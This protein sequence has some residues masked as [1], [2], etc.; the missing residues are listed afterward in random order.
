MGTVMR[1]DT[2]QRSHRL[3]VTQPVHPTTTTTRSP[4]TA[5]GQ[6]RGCA[7]PDEPCYPSLTAL[8]GM[9][10]SAL[11]NRPRMGAD[12]IGPTGRLAMTLRVT[13][14]TS[15]LALARDRGYDGQRMGVDTVQPSRRLAHPTTRLPDYPTTRLPDYPTTRLPATRLPRAASRSADHATEGRSAPVLSAAPSIRV[16]PSRHASVPPTVDLVGR[17]QQPK[18]PTA[19][20]ACRRRDARQ[21]RHGIQD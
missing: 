15:S 7:G 20:Y 14:V 17:H 19:A 21:R 8:T 10:S 4:R 3:A 1:D 6:G 13:R 5:D 16:A 2:S 11:Y 18:T 12:A 9:W